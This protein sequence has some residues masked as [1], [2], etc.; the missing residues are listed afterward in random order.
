[1]PFFYR[2]VI[3]PAA[4]RFSLIVGV[5]GAGD[6]GGAVPAP[7]V[8]TPRP[9]RIGGWH[10]LVPDRLPQPVGPAMSLPAGAPACP[11]EHPSVVTSVF[12]AIQA[13]Q[14]ENP[15]V[16][17]RVLV[18]VRGH[19]DPWKDQKFRWK[20]SRP[21]RASVSPPFLKSILRYSS[22]PPIVMPGTIV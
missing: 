21:T 20:R 10:A 19:S 14:Q 12:R 17:R 11:Q 6:G 15:A 4:Q 9:C 22:S 13:A 7:H 18:S 3:L 16:A 1:M 5:I 2:R 8:R